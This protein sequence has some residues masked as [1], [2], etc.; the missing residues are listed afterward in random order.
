MGVTEQ[1]REYSVAGF[2]ERVEPVLADG[3]AAFA[4]T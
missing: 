4:K 3:I 1:Y 2:A